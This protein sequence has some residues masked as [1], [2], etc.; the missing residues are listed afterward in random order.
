MLVA[1]RSIEN[2]LPSS[3]AIPPLTGPS[4]LLQFALQPIT[5]SIDRDLLNG[6]PATA[7]QIR[8]GRSIT[9]TYETPQ[10]REILDT[11]PVLVI[12]TH[13]N[14]IDALGI[15]SALPN[16]KTSV[17]ASANM[18]RLF[19]SEA[20]K[21]CIPLITDYSHG[22]Q[23]RR[24]LAKSLRP[25]PLPISLARDIRD[26]A[27][28]TIQERLERGEAVIYFVDGAGSDPQRPW[29]KNIGHVLQQISPDTHIVFAYIEGA[30]ARHIIP[31]VRRGIAAPTVAL[32]RPYR[33]SEFSTNANPSQTMQNLQTTYR[34]F[35]RAV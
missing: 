10:T 31:I 24:G 30:D 3:V 22:A 14:Y 2:S 18:T 12:A 19:G 13:Q 11:Q 6:S 17:V 34:Q 9:P 33:V 1:T 25:S 4:R 26:Q 23:A 21:H 32:S 8:L 7:A 5:R 15:I 20:Q 29:G 35:S 16:R 27:N 28:Q